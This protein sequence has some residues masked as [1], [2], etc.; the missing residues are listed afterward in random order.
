MTGIRQGVSVTRCI[1]QA[2]LIS[3]PVTL[4]FFFFIF[5]T[6]WALL[7]S[8]MAYIAGIFDAHSEISFN[9][10][11]Q[12]S[13]LALRGSFIGLATGLDRAGLGIGMVMAGVFLDH[14]LIIDV[15]LG[16]YLPTVLLCCAAYYY[17][18]KY[19]LKGI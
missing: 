16:F 3:V 19:L 6:E 17:F 7:I 4:V 15:L 5:V 11:A 13:P 9:T 14:A 2:Y 10:L 12:S 1:E 18:S 8:T